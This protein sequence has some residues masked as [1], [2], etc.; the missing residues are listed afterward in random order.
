MT[1]TIASVGAIILF[2][3]LFAIGVY[4]RR[5]D[6]N[7]IAEVPAIVLDTIAA[8]PPLEPIEIIPEEPKPEPMADFK[9]AYGIVRYHEAGYQK[10]PQDKG[11]RNSL[12]QLVG[13]NWGINAQVYETYLGRPPSENDM[14]SMPRTTAEKIFKRLYW[15]RIYGDT[16]PD[17]QLANIFL[18][19]IVNHGQGVRLMQEVLGVFRDNRYGP[20]THAALLAGNPRTIFNAYKSRRRKYYHQL[21]AADLT[22]RVFLN[23]WINRI[24]SFHYEGSPNSGSNVLAGV[25]LAIITYFYLS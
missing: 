1:I 10:L 4:R 17:Q 3:L 7:E 15:D 16:I 2:S 23:G 11:N 14:R 8:E 9:I 21:V 25:A 12:G 22:Q 18:D 24:E 6:T 19:G 13:T 5:T 20:L